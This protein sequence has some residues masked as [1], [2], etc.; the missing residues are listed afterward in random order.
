ME[1]AEEGKGA[2]QTL[3]GNKPR[4]YFAESGSRD[5]SRWFHAR[6]TADDSLPKKLANFVKTTAEAKKKRDLVQLRRNAG[7]QPYPVTA[8]RVGKLFDAFEVRRFLPEA[9]E[10]SLKIFPA[11]QHAAPDTE[12]SPGPRCVVLDLSSRSLKVADV[13]VLQSL[14][15]LDQKVDGRLAPALDLAGAFQRRGGRLRHC[16]CLMMSRALFVHSRS[17]SRF[18]LSLLLLAWARRLSRLRG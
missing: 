14:A 8:A 4:S 1:A 10:A 7:V 13:V 15:D 11:C 2:D 12:L 5:G 17:R 18:R 9:A 6:S 16:G 3:V